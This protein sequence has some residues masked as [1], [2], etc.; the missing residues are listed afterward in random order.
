MFKV[1]GFRKFRGQK[2]I[3]G[4]GENYGVGL[5]TLLYL[6][7]CDALRYFLQQDKY[8]LKYEV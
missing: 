3:E 5:A 6:R 2:W 1:C 7:A 4:G 8:L